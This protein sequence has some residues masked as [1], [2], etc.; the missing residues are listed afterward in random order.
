[1]WPVLTNI[2]NVVR[3]QASLQVERGKVKSKFKSHDH[4]T[5]QTL[6]LTVTLTFDA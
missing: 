2:L 1:M 3:S 4:H 5:H 6:T